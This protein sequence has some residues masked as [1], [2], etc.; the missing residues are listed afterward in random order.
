MRQLVQARSARQ[1]VDT[2]KAPG[3][4]SNFTGLP[5]D[6]E[7]FPIT[8]PISSKQME[9]HIEMVRTDFKL[10]FKDIMDRDHFEDKIYFRDPITNVSFFRGYQFVVQF[11]RFFLA[12]IY[13]L[14]EVQQAGEQEILVKW[15]WTMNFWWNRYT[16]FK[17]FWDPRFAFSGLT[18][19][20]YN[21]DTGK[22]NKHVDA[23]DAVEDNEFFSLEAFVFAFKQMAQVSTPPNRFTP[24]FQIYK[25]YKDWE[26]R[27]YR[28]FITAE[29]CLKDLQESNDAVGP[30]PG[31]KAQHERAQR[32]KAEVLLERYLALGNDRE[33]Y[34]ELTTPLFVSNDDM[35]SLM[36]PGYK[37]IEDLPKPHKHSLIKLKQHPER[38]YATAIFSGT[39]SEEDLQH[40]VRFLRG[41]LDKEGSQ[42]ADD[43]WIFARYNK[44]IW[45][46]GPFRR[47]D[48][49][50]PLVEDSV[51][52]WHGV[53]W[54]FVTRIIAHPV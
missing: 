25:R 20:G 22:W 18:I 24:E 42:A 29:I 40:K 37:R 38:F 15:S 5:K 12:P 13:E 7:D 54:E 11:L 26:I 50:I 51:D 6:K 8:T 39:P 47:N 35:F 45:P 21:P 48:L 2:A 14:H 30:G 36:V 19:L 49:L 46:K 28:P 31:I 3:S 1:T 9:E 52:L 27:R 44:E 16:P 32:Q 43:S 53:D 4:Q 10:V 33:E 23:W 17:Y 34:F 41:R